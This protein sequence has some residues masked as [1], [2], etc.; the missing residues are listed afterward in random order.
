MIGV[1]HTCPHCLLA[2]PG[3]SSMLSHIEL[4]V[5]LLTIPTLCLHILFPGDMLPPLYLLT[6]LGSSFIHSV[7]FTTCCVLGMFQMSEIV[8]NKTDQNLCPHGAS[9]SGRTELTL[10][11]LVPFAMSYPL[12]KKKKEITFS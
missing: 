10:G 2:F 9:H 3:K 7:F 11:A 8:M 5:H 1:F 6:S 4:S 12:K